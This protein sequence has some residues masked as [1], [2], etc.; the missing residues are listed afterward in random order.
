[1]DP[2]SR[3]DGYVRRACAPPLE[4]YLRLRRDSGLS[5][6][7]AEQAEP[8]LSGS[9]AW[10]HVTDAEGVVV[11]MGRV[12]GDGGWYFHLADMATDPEHQGRGLGRGVLDSLVREILRRAPADPYITLIGDPPGQHLYTTYGFTDVSPSLGMVLPG[13]A[14]GPV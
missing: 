13:H 6:K 14:A 2:A 4:D 8:A 7:T 9:W 10:R 5:P 1:M 12:I 3:T 11:A